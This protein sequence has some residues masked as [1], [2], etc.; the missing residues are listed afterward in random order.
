MYNIQLN[1]LFFFILDLK[2]C[3]WMIRN[4][5]VL[6]FFS[7]FLKKKPWNFHLSNKQSIYQFVKWLQIWCSHHLGTQK[8]NFFTTAQKRWLKLVLSFFKLHTLHHFIET[9]C[10]DS[11]FQLATKT[12][13]NTKKL[14]SWSCIIL[15]HPIKYKRV[16]R[17]S[18]KYMASAQWWLITLCL[19]NNSSLLT[20]SK[21]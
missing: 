10:K 18:Q 6:M 16:S 15:A 20:Q 19:A 14:I 8:C 3:L 13:Q 4:A 21:C 9:K 12:K 1:G 17:C 7:T 2:S 11:S 5:V